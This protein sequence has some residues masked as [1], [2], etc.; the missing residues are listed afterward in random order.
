MKMT[1]RAVRL[2][3]TMALALV[4]TQCNDGGSNENEPGGGGAPGSVGAAAAG[5]GNDVK[6]SAAGDSSMA[7]SKVECSGETKKFAADDGKIQYAG[8]IDWTDEAKPMFSAAGVTI[9]ARFVGES[10]TV[11]LEDQNRYNKRNYF[12]V[13]IDDKKPH[14]LAPEIGTT[15]YEIPVELECGEHTVTVIK[16]TESN[17]GYAEFVGLE[18]EQLL[19]PPARPSRKIEVIGDSITCGAGVEAKDKS[20][21][22]DEDGWGQPYHNVHKAYGSVVARIL[23]AEVHTTCV[24]GIGLVQNY[25]D[26]PRKEPDP[27]A[28]LRTMPEVYGLLYLE[29]ADSPKWDTELYVP[30]AILVALGTNDFSPGQGYETDPGDARPPLD[31][32]VFTDAYIGFVEDLKAYYPG[33]HVFV[34]G[35]TMLGNGWPSDAPYTYESMTTQRNALTAVEE[36]FADD[37]DVKV[38]KFYPHRLTGAGC[39][40]H[41]DVEQQ[42]YTGQEIATFVKEQMD[43]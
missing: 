2:I 26:D 3:E 4:V 19:E 11:L 20:P 15:S 9:R 25:N 41:P 8:R 28:D 34:L 22:C 40:S 12:D 1:M 36:H 31:E 21:E 38:S 16:R 30:D 7:G 35:S 13:I 18:V 27:D 23:D 43:W 24:S 6:G 32:Q 10:L 42:E 5:R 33:A 29:Q 14:K 37:P 17:I 39:G